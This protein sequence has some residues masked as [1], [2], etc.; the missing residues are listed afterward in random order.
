LLAEE[1]GAPNENEGAD[2]VPA[3]GAAGFEVNENIPAGAGG[4]ALAP[5]EKGLAAGGGAGAAQDELTG[6]ELLFGT[7]D[8]L[9]GASFSFDP[10]SSSIFNACS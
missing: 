5:K 7:A 2:V 4:G 9:L 8:V 3:E 6:C 10:P 1:E